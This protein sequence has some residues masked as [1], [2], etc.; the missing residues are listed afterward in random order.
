MRVIN[1]VNS[2][3]AAPARARS[4][5]LSVCLVLLAGLFPASSCL[6]GQQAKPTE[7]DVKAAYLYNF[8]KFIDWPAKIAS[9]QDS[10]FTICILGQDSFGPAL[11][12]ALANHTIDGKGLVAKRISKSQEALNC[13]VLF[14]SSSEQNHLK[15][16]LATLDKASLLTVSDAP[17]FAE[18]GG[19]IQFV[20]DGNK[21]RFEVNV[22]NAQR[23]GLVLRSEL[24]K[25]AI[26][27]IG[28]PQ[29]GG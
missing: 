5:R 19:M 14:I 4:Q 2:R 23:A 29:P 24:L 20:M 13:R 18:R 28:N 7:Y 22:T 6:H 17:D 25:V 11:D 9:D 26:T 1:S 27:V 8:V 3:Q 12:A 16:I 15:D 21:V 10:S